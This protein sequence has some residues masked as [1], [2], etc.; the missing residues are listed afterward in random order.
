MPA[1]ETPFT[2]H[3]LVLS[4]GGSLDYAL[5]LPE[6]FEPERA[7]PLLLALPPGAQSREMVEASMNRYWGE[8]ARQRNWIVV[9][10]VARD[11]RLFFKGGEE[12]IPALLRHL[13]VTY[14]I[15]GNRMHLAGSSNGG[16]SAFRIAT[17]QPYEF[18]SLVV[19]PG[20]PPADRDRALLADLTHLSIRMF[21]GEDDT[22]WVSAMRETLFDLQA[23]NADVQAQAFPGEGHVPPSLDGEVIMDLMVALHGEQDSASPSRDVA[24]VLDDFHDAASK[25]DE[26]RYFGHFSPEAIFFGTAPEERWSLAEFRSY[27]KDAFKRDSAWIYVPQERHIDLAP[28]GRVAWFD[29]VLVNSKY[30]VCRGTG[31]LRLVDKTWKVCQYNLSVPVPNDMLP[32]VADEIRRNLKRAK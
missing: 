11:G 8:Q 5:V 14:K 10:P 15:E 31:V 4:D 21:A 25:A 6:L 23:L 27:A 20:F 3:S 12:Q 30:G 16:R 24:R 2:Y 18:Q 9:S 7:Y 13:R 19:L 29:E 1:Q 26:E 32:G 28:E 17:Q 22:R